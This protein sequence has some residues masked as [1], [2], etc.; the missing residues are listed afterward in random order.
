MVK[1]A[2]CLLS[3][4]GTLEGRFPPGECPRAIARAP[5]RPALC[6]ETE[7]DIRWSHGRRD[8]G[9][10][11]PL[12]EATRPH[13]DSSAGRAPVADPGLEANVMDDSFRRH[14]Y[15]RPAAGRVATTMS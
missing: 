7:D 6:A 3:R 5:H 14:R 13:L 11:D 12:T 10:L 9:G 8:R 2:A 15:A 4:P 1:V